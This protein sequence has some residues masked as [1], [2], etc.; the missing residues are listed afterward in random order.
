MQKFLEKREQYSG[1]DPI[2][3]SRLRLDEKLPP[4][5]EYKDKKLM[6]S[7]QFDKEFAAKFG[8]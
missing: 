6:T 7:K 1:T 2:V 5:E 4:F 3:R 8:E